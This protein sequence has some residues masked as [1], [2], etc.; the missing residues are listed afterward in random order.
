MPITLSYDDVYSHAASQSAGKPRTTF[1]TLSRAPSRHRLW[2][3]P[4]CS[5]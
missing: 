1:I 2:P 4:P 3:H 5:R